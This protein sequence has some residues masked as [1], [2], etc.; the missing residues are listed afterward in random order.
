MVVR[1]IVG[2]WKKNSEKSSAPPPQ[3]KILLMKIDLKK[4][5]VGNYN[6]ASHSTR[7]L[8]NCVRPSKKTRGM[9][10]LKTV[11]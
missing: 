1:E 11:T 5:I 9:N 7:G 4:K 2:A 3:E 6:C 8:S 10:E